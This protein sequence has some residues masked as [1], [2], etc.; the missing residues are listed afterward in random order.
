MTSHQ[1]ALRKIA[2]RPAVWGLCLL[3]AA[4]GKPVPQQAEPSPI[5]VKTYQ[6]GTDATPTAPEFPVTVVRD[7]ESNLSFRVGGVIQALAVRAGQS[8]QA[9]QALATL[10]PTPYVSNRLRA[11]A[12]V[13][14]LQNAVRRNEELLRAG[15]VSA[16]LKQDT[17]DA[18]AAA[19]AA[20]GSAQ[21]DEESA[22]IKAPFAGVVLA[23]DAELGETVAAGQRVL[24]IADLG[25]TVLA[26]ASVPSAI[27]RGLRVG[28]RAQVR[29][30]PGTLAATIRQ[31][32]ALSDPRTASVTVDLVLQQAAAV[33]SGTLGSVA[34][35]HKAPDK[36]AGP[37]L[38]VPEALLESKDGVG[39]VYVLDA[40]Q[41]VA[42]RAS[43]Q[44]LGFEG[45][46]IRVAGLARG[47]KVLTSGAGF[48]SDGQ[49]V[50]EIRP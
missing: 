26:K 13:S 2:P 50:R 33:A 8:V 41:S 49:K 19:Q 40:S 21:Y 34:F 48:V 38:L 17:E 11:E 9:G 31:V 30:G 5:A 23:R 32:G 46:L 25:S 7:R 45:E 6:I 4:C 14:R 28:G 15:A 1:N 43:I 16:A 36:D 3:L 37:L 27:A 39:A 47:A 10:R 42:R 12:E 18:L 20:L 22:T 35:T 24:R 44:V 29:V